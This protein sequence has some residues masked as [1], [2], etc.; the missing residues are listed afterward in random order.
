VLIQE[1]TSIVFVKHAR[2]SPWVVL[3]RLYIL[4]LDEQ[5]VAW[6]GGLDFERARQVVDLSE[7]NILHVVGAIIVADLAT[8]PIQ[9]FDLHNLAVLDGTAEGD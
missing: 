2:K 9:T 3:E 8:S 5:N 4:N 7:I 1:P 6:L